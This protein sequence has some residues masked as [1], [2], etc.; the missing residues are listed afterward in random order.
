MN[1]RWALQLTRIYAKGAEAY[2]NGKTLDDNPYASGYGGGGNLQ[3]QRRRYWADGWRSA[4]GQHGYPCEA[5]LY[6]K[7]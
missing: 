4:S 7:K 6:T 2:H 5:S 1:Y 3:R